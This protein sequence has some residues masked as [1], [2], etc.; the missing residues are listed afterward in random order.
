[1]CHHRGKFF[2]SAIADTTG[3]AVLCT[4]GKLSGSAPFNTGV[5]AVVGHRQEVILP[6]PGLDLFWAQLHQGDSENARLIPMFDLTGNLT[7]VTAAAIAI[8]DQ[9]AEAF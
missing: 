7:A 9:Q 2:D 6:F 4:T 3:L 5:T 1:V 8:I